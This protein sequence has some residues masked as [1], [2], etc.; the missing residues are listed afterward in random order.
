M[1]TVTPLASVRPLVMNNVPLSLRLLPMMTLFS[2]PLAE[3]S[4]VPVMVPPVI[5]PLRVPKPPAPKMPALPMSKV[6]PVLS[7]TPVR[8][9]APPVR[10]MLPKGIAA[11]VK[12]PPS[13]STPPLKLIVPAAF[14]HA[15]VNS[16]I[17]VDTL[18]VPV[19]MTWK[20]CVEAEV[21]FSA[22]ALLNVPF[23]PLL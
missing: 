3:V 19:L 1:F 13:P 5:L 15:P 4:V 20:D 21:L 11:V 7:S 16:I 9:S 18:I 12:L 2:V 8:F 10:L 17:P 23:T 22:P 6:E 14:V